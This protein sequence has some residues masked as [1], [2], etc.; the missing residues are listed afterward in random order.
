MKKIFQQLQMEA[1]RIARK[2]PAPDFYRE[3]EAEVARSY[4]FF[5]SDAAT[6]QIHLCVRETIENDYGHGI[7]HCKK[8]ALDAGVLML[9]EGGRAGYG[10]N[11]LSRLL[12]LAHCAGL[13]HDICRKEK[14]HA[15]A[16]AVEAEKILSARGFQGGEASDI[17]RAI[18]NHEA[19]GDNKGADSRE[20]ELL[21]GCLYDADKFRWGPENFTHTVWSMVAYKDVSIDDFIT[22]YPRGMAFLQK[23]RETFR[24]P[25]GRVYGPQFIDIGLAIGKDLYELIRSDY[26]DPRTS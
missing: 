26:L 8:V 23:I 5:I 16:G 14:K 20:G 15:R 7:D 3:F 4:L 11:Q 10:E 24:T 22:Y 6:R 19:F 25:T 18:A 21:S 13:L 9:V 17:C 2:Y 1:I 12:R